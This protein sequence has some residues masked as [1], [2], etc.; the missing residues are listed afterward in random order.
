VRGDSGSPN[1]N[2]NRRL[3]EF[4]HGLLIMMWD[5]PGSEI[6]GETKRNYLTADSRFIEG[7]GGAENSRE[8][9]IWCL[10]PASRRPGV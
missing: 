10:S 7:A 4:V 3:M 6:E 9:P 1:D 8:K 5:R 2:A